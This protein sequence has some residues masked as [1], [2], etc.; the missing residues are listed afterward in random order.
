MV[1]AAVIAL[2]V[3]VTVVGGSNPQPAAA[4]PLVALS[5]K[6][7]QSPAPTGDATLVIRTQTGPG[8]PANTFSE[9]YVDDGRRFGGS[10]SEELGQDIASGGEQDGGLARILAAA[11][12]ALD[13]PIDQ[14]RTGMA[15]AALDPNATARSAVDT[16]V[17]AATVKN[18]D[19]ATAKKLRSGT[20]MDPTT[21]LEGNVWSNSLDAL[22]FGAGRPQVRAGV[23]RLLAS[24]EHV[25][26]AKGE[27][28]GRPTLVLTARHFT[29][30]Y[31]EQLTID[32]ETG[33]PLGFIGGTSGAPPSIVMS[34][35]VSRVTTSDLAHR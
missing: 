22:V 19:A 33:Q 6:V 23:L 27:Q 35:E 3:G 30:G 8:A 5:Q 2:V 25:T 9:L 21:H 29:D 12:A 20:T 10:T 17:D 4:A 34:Y 14:A 11:T 15:D 7:E 32:A 13:L 31:E 28:D 1:G 26:V 24:C 16:G 18:L